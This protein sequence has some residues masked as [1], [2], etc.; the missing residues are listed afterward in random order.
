MLVATGVGEDGTKVVLSLR[1]GDNESAGAWSASFK[2]LKRRGLDESAVRLGVMDGL[3]G[4]E[5]VFEEE[6]SRARVHRCQRHVARNILARAPRNAKKVVADN[7]RSIFYA[8]S[9]QKADEFAA[10][11]AANWEKD[12]PSAVKCLSNSLDA[13]LIFFSFLFGQ[14]KP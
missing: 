6:F 1:S 8:S 10:S 9:R 7:L 14:I 13:G 4:L 11:F 12:T 2:D 3:S 5:K